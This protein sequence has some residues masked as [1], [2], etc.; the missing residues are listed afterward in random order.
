MITVYGISNCDTVKRARAWLAAQGLPVEFHDYKKQGVPAELLPAWLKAFGRDRLLNRA[1]TTWRKLD[2][3]TRAAVVDDASAAALMQAEPS[4][5]KRPVVRWADGS[6][7][8]GFTPEA[9]AAQQ[10]GR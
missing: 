4:V 5:I 3:A 2:E 9:F 1:G 6:L 10:G 8:L 7:T